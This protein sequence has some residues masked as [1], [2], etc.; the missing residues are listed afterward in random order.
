MLSPGRG[1]AREQER[2]QAQLDAFHD[3]LIRDLQA[4]ARNPADDR[5]CVSA[6]SLERSQH[7]FRV[8]PRLRG[9]VPCEHH[10]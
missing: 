9:E 6:D 2:L 10:R 5:E 4:Q 3:E 1:P 8:R 7:E